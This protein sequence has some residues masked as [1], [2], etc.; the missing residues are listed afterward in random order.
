MMEGGEPQPQQQS[1][2]AKQFYGA[3]LNADPKVIELQLKTSDIL[4][5]I[6]DFLEGKIVIGPEIHSGQE[7]ANS[8]GRNRIM[9]TSLNS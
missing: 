9:S 1:R 5:Q 8:H 3:G 7:L 2:T 4:A 6:Y